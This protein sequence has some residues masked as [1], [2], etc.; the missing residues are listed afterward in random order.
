MD[1]KRRRQWMVL[2]TGTLLSCLVLGGTLLAD[3]YEDPM[4][5]TTGTGGTT[6][7]GGE[8]VLSEDSGGS[9]LDTRE[10]LDP[11]LTTTLT[12]EDTTSS[13]DETL[14]VTS[15]PTFEVETQ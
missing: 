14:V 6:V 13:S 10:A 11:Q 4:G 3:E 2:L 7:V 12:M 8:V 5:G 9:E 15:D 1:T